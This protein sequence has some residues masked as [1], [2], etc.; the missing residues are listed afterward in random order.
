[1]SPYRYLRRKWRVLVHCVKWG[2]KSREFSVWDWESVLDVLDYQMELMVDALESPHAL[3][4]GDWR[5]RLAEM[6]ALRLEISRVLNP[7]DFYPDLTSWNLSDPVTDQD[8][9]SLSK[10][11][12]DEE[13]AI[14]KALNKVCL[15][16][17]RRLRYW[18]D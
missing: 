18:W 12:D 17:K 1:M 13:E 10:A 14:Q 11:M 5:R 7:P 15:I 6:K 2:W 8:R 16:L 3:R 9:K 4:G